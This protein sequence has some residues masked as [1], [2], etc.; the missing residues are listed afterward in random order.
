LLVP[1]NYSSP[2]PSIENLKSEI[3]NDRIENFGL[4]QSNDEND[5]NRMIST[6]KPYSQRQFNQPETSRYEENN[7]CE[8]VPESNLIR[9]SNLLHGIPLFID[10]NVIVTDLMIDQ[11]KQLAYLLSSLALEVFQIS[12]ETMHLFRDIS[13]GKKI[14]KNNIFLKYLF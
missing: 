8:F 5:I 14:L 7:S 9:Y 4:Y 3:V 12:K 11:G 1:N 10:K 6:S 13:S 2:S